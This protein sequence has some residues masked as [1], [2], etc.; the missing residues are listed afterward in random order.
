MIYGAMSRIMVAGWRGRLEAF[1]PAWRPRPL[2][3]KLALEGVF[4]EV[5]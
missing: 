1:T 2:F 3:A 5:R 4:S